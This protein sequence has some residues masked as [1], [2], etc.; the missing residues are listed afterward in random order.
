MLDGKRDD[1]MYKKYRARNSSPGC[2][3]GEKGESKRGGRGCRL[4]VEVVRV[5]VVEGGRI[6]R[7]LERVWLCLFF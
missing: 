3:K 4:G 1:K 5:Q 6:N 2:R 7:Q